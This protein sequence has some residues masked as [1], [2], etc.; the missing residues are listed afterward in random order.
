MIAIMTAIPLLPGKS[1]VWR[2]WVQELQGLRQAE[3]AEALRRWGISRTRSWISE[4]RGSDVVVTYFELQDPDALSDI[5]E[6]SQHPFDIWYRQ[7]LQEFHGMDVRQIR[8]RRLDPVL[9]W[10][11]QE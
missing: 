10:P 7:K 2:R 6:T 3:Y 4:A 8:R 9:V 11:E 5:L 1:E